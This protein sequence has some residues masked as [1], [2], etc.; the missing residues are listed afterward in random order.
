MKPSKVPKKHWV[1]KRM[2]YVRHWAGKNER[3]FGLSRPIGC[4]IRF[5]ELNISKPQIQ[6]DSNATRM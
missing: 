3:W 4:M 1:R 2:G 6:W 5:R